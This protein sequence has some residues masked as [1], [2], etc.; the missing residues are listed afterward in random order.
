MAYFLNFF[1][2]RFS[3]ERRQV[4]DE[5]ELVVGIT[6]EGGARNKRTS[7]ATLLCKLFLR[8][9]VNATTTLFT[10]DDVIIESV[11]QQR[12]GRIMQS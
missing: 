9:Y 2:L 6:N 1:C 11:Q 3:N 12:G 10:R 7:G 8:S 5:H 4:R